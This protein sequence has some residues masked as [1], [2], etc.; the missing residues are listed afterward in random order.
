M[1]K[2]Y[3]KR[4]NMEKVLVVVDCQ[5]DFIT[6]SLANPAAEA[7]V[8]NIVNKIRKETKAGDVIF[9][10]LD[11]HAENYLETREGKLLPVVHCIKGTDG[12]KIDDNVLAALNDAELR[13]VKVHYVEKPTFGSYNLVK[14]AEL[15]VGADTEIEIVGFVSSICVVS[16][17]LM[18]KAKFYENEVSLDS[19]C[20]AGLGEANNEAALEVMRS[21]QITVK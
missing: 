14:L 9:A 12:W 6:G 21:C 16:N 5:N 4:E 17:A 3:N 8:P 20:T 7:A 11:T 1:N 13:G 10:T 18:L 15:Y 19:S 2:N